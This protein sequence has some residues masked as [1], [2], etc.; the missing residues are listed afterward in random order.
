MTAKQP[1]LCRREDSLLLIVDIQERLAAAMPR[2]ACEIVFRNTAI[3]SRAAEKLEVPRLLTEQYPKG[4]GPTES[5]VLE[6][7]TGNVGRFEKT[8]FSCCGGTGFASALLNSG[9]RQVIIAGME[10]HV[11]VLQTAMELSTDGFEV[12]V[13]EDATCSRNPD[14]H[15]NAMRRLRRAGVVV[16]N[17]E[18][19]VFEWLRDSRHEHFKEISALLR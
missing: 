16:A 4:L 9:R 8:S 7:L 15:R 13:V 18:S 5:V 11:C 10:A 1:L 3:L 14:N 12:Y 2:E 17:T 19:V 6:H